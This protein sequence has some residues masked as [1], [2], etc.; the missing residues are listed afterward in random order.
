MKFAD[1]TAEQ[2][3]S[4]PVGAP[5]HTTLGD[6]VFSFVRFGPPEWAVPEAICVHLDSQQHRIEYQG[7][8]FS[9]NNVWTVDKEE[10]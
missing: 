1:M 4:F 5:V 2:V 6:G 8:I 10:K 3:R 9:P 7:T